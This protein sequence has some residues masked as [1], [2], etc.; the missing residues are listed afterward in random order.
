MK[1]ILL[2]L[3]LAAAV[4]SCATTKTEKTDPFAFLSISSVEKDCK[5]DEQW[6]IAVLGLYSYVVKFESCL[7][8]EPLLIISVDT[9][10]YP[11]NINRTSINLLAQHYVAF[12]NREDKKHIYTYKKLKEEQHKKTLTFFFNIAS[13][14]VPCEGPI[15]QKGE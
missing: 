3:T 13:K 7:T 11:E 4:A 10:K 14:Q 15:C 12:L 6:R 5:P 9:A 1:K 2:F 8:I